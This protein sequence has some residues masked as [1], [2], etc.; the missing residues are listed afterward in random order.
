MAFDPEAAAGPGVAGTPGQQPP[1]ARAASSN[2]GAPQPGWPGWSAEGPPGVEQS[3][4]S[5]HAVEADASGASQ[6]A[7]AG[8]PAAP[9]MQTIRTLVRLP[10]AT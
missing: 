6:P 7:G 4:A 9:L 2:A 1:Q 10:N 5:R 8:R 3:R